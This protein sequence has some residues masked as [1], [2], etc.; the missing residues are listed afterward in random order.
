MLRSWA[1]PNPKVFGSP[2]SEQSG[3]DL[4][5]LRW[6]NSGRPRGPASH[7][8]WQRTQWRK[9]SRASPACAQM[10]RVLTSALNL[11]RPWRPPGARS[12]AS[13]GTAREPEIQVRALEGPDKGECAVSGSTPE[14]TGASRGRGENG[15]MASA[16]TAHRKTRTCSGKEGR[17]VRF[18]IWSQISCIP[19]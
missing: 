16:S 11:T 3:E 19:F 4:S 7:A 14:A 5:A 15:T 2:R 12:G 13:D 9:W 6:S 1:S 10:L 18:R 17:S 8:Q